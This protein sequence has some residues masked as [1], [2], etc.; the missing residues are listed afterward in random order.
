MLNRL[1]LEADV[2][3]LVS[4]RDDFLFR[5]HEVEALSPIFS[6]LTPIGPPV[7]GALRRALV[8]PTTKCGYRFED[9]ELVEEMLGEVEGER[10]A[11]PLLAFAAARLWDRR[12]RETGFLTRDAFRE[13]G[14]V[15]G[16]LA[17]H[18]EMTIDRVGTERIATVRELFRNLITAEGT[19]AVREWSELLSVFD[20]VDTKK[21]VG[22]GF[23][24]S[25]KSAQ[26][27]LHELINARLLTSY[28]VREDEKE[29]VRRVEIIH[30]SLLVNWPRLV[31][32][33]TQDA[34]AAQLRDQLRQAAKTWN[35]QGR[36]DDTLWTGSA[37]REFAVWRERYRGGLTDI[38]EAF[39]SA[40]TSL[41][42]RRRRRR[43]LVSTLA[44]CALVAVLAVVTG[45][46]R[47]SV[48]Q[49]RRAEASKLVT[50]GRAAIEKERTEALAYAIASLQF[51]DTSEARK[52]ALRALWEGP[53]ATIAPN[54]EMQAFRL[55]FSPDGDHLAA[56]YGWRKK[57]QVVVF[58]RDGGPAIHLREVEGNSAVWSL[59]FSPD[60]G[61]LLG[62]VDVGEVP[63]WRTDTWQL[64]RILE[65][66]N[67]EW[68][69]AYFEPGGETILSFAM[70]TLV[71]AGP[72]RRPLV[73][74]IV[75]RWQLRAGPPLLVDAYQAFRT[76]LPPVPDF[77]RGVVPVPSASRVELH[78]LES[79]GDQRG[80]VIA[81]Y[82]PEVEPRYD[83]AFDP[84]KDRLALTDSEANLRLWPLAG[85]G[86]EFERG[87]EA[88]KTV[89]RT[90]FS[91]DGS[92]LA[93]AGG[94]D[95]GRL[96]DLEG[97]T[98]AEP[99][100]IDKVGWQM[101]D[102]AFSPD[103]QWLATA[104]FDYNVSLWPLTKRYSRVLRGH[105]SAVLSSAFSPDGS[106]YFT[107]GVDDGR[108]LS[109]D[110]SGGAGRRP[111]VL[112]EEPMA[113]NGWLS[114]DPHGRF[115]MC[116]LGGFG[117]H[118]IPLDGGDPT[119]IDGLPD[120]QL[121]LDPTGRFAAA[122]DGFSVGTVIVVDLDSGESWDL[123]APGDGNVSGWAFDRE[124]RLL[125]ARGGVLG[126]WDPATRET[127]ILLTGEGQIGFGEGAVS[128]GHVAIR[129]FDDGR[130]YIGGR[131]RSILD[132]EDGTRTVLP[133]AD[134]PQRR[135]AHDAFDPAGSVVATGRR[136]GV[137][138]V[139]L[140][141]GDTRHLLVGHEAAYVIPQV[142]PD[143][144]WVASAGQDGSVRLWP[145]PD[146]SKPPLHT[147]PYDELMT[148]LRTLTN[149]RIVPDPE[150]PTGYR[151]TADETAWRGWAE[152]PEW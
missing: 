149:L 25:R 59:D 132:P 35:D 69:E 64:E 14:G 47:Q 116:S 138:E 88:P 125:V 113:W 46:W 106:H 70:R 54:K 107:V 134:Q 13:I 91:P 34:D 55:A 66:P 82:P 114:P 3:V 148:K 151:L 31:R 103:G 40:M 10:G 9:D 33:Q 73:E 29:P 87:F 108:V 74:W 45:L 65:V 101:S 24:P 97:P 100:Q 123:E 119:S 11:L 144:R 102:L 137:I 122:I 150:E 16:A 22:E 110:L 12:D 83:A 146:L 104:G 4:M 71:E 68:V 36:S 95:G 41:A 98:G 141:S 23:I 48:R 67:A 17:Q 2:H 126:R 133:A 76:G 43:R 105:D 60:G 18:A 75:H 19:R 128:S 81:S 78:R 131:E 52:L 96:W 51:A 112:F 50:L 44:V 79:L 109:W 28:E 145:M 136:D 111:T 121:V 56:G 135:L 127:E 84:V 120:G 89:F 129:V 130:I 26:E 143:G 49:T 53:P 5:C 27:V 140:V 32:W 80:R 8:R 117:T 152:V 139:G 115:L 85:D 61:W 21:T 90:R 72:S 30:E 15:G 6:E 39:A 94:D 142:S 37:Y 77:T 1:V 93:Q 124:G 92:L 42:T 99:L 7:G 62:S 86:S 147:L 20:S 118:I 63:V 58:P 57:G 38:E